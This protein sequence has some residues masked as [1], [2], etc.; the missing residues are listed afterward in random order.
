MFFK[1]ALKYSRNMDYNKVCRE[2]QMWDS[3]IL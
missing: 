2:L 1:S 3:K